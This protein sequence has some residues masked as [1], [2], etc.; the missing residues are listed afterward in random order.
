[1]LEAKGR[2]IPGSERGSKTGYTWE[3]V[4]SQVVLL[5]YLYL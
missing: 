2:N 4:I 1:M 5:E 3:A